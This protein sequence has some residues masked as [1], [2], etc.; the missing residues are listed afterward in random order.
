MIWNYDFMNFSTID[1]SSFYLLIFFTFV[2]S[3][4][5][6]FTWDFLIRTKIASY[7]MIEERYRLG[8]LWGPF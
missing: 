8:S 4:I 5:Y 2:T 6:F 3:F 7:S 1:G